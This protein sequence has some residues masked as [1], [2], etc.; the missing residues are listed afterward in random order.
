M[1][2]RICR[3]VEGHFICSVD[4]LIWARVDVKKRVIKTIATISD[5][6]VTYAAHTYELNYNITELTQNHFMST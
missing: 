4:T 1:F 6:T 2:S 3:S 5:L